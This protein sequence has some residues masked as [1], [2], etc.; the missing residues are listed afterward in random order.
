MNKTNY[1]KINCFLRFLFTMPSVW[2]DPFVEPFIQQQT[3]A[4]AQQFYEHLIHDHA[5]HDQFINEP[6]QSG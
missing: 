2:F 6:Q 4:V 5:N 1:N 3:Q